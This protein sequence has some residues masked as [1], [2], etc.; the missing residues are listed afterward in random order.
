M[1]NGRLSYNGEPLV[2]SVQPIEDGGSYLATNANTGDR[3]AVGGIGCRSV[4]GGPRRCQGVGFLHLRRGSLSPAALNAFNQRTNYG[5]LTVA[6]GEFVRLS[7]EHVVFGGVSADNVRATGEA[8]LA[9]VRDLNAFT[10]R[11]ADARPG[12]G[13]IDQVASPFNDA[14][15][16]RVEAT[17]V[18]AARD[19]ALDAL[20]ENDFGDMEAQRDATLSR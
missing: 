2:F 5:K 9:R 16:G 4:S 1:V 12:A 19:P 7:L 11:Q 13:K 3:L 15:Q 14:P 10:G 8:F 18:S 20:L 6:N 17:T